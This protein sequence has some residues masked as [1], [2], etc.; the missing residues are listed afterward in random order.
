LITIN[1]KLVEPVAAKFNLS[2][3]S[4][5]EVITDPSVPYYGSIVLSG[6][7]WGNRLEPAPTSPYKGS[8]SFDIFSGTIKSVYNT[9]RGLEGDDNIKVYPSY[10]SGNTGRTPTD[11]K[12]SLNSRASIDTKHCWKLSENIYRYNHQN[13]L[14]GR[15]MGNIHTVD[16][17]KLAALRTILELTAEI[18]GMSVDSLLEMVEFFTTLILNAD[19]VDNL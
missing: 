15:G 14:G 11:L 3:T 1:T 17:S 2:L 6:G 12:Y 9:H 19:E 7:S 13:G 18:L 4:F 10:M 16:E 8:V 5:G